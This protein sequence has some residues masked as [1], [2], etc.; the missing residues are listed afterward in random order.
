[1]NILLLLLLPFAPDLGR[2]GAPEYHVREWESRRCD[3]PISAL[4]LPDRTDCPEVCARIAALKKR[5]RPLSRLQVEMRTL[6][7]DFPRWVAQYLLLGRS[8]VARDF[9][10]FRAEIYWSYDHCR[11]LF[12]MLPPPPAAGNQWGV[13]GG[14]LFPL[15]YDVWLDYLDYHQGRAPAPR[16]VAR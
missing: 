15:D 9:E 10:F 13:W 7:G 12:A 2:L 14:V 5:W 6:D 11:A 8:I 4:L 1:V 3:N 16:E